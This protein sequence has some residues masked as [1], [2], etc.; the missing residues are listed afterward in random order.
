MGQSGA[1]SR[2]NNDNNKFTLLANGIKMKFEKRV[3][4]RKFT[5]V[6]LTFKR[7]LGAGWKVHMFTR[8]PLDR[9]VCLVIMTRTDGAKHRTTIA[10]VPYFEGLG[11]LTNTLG[12]PQILGCE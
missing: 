3:S 8:N 11:R 1:L 9:N 7:F 2:R 5:S 10:R 6:V 4:F 12:L